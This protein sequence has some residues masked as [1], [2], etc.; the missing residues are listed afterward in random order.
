MSATTWKQDAQRTM[1]V[2]NATSTD[3]YYKQASNRFNRSNS[4]DRA[5][6]GHGDTITFTDASGKV[7]EGKALRCFPGTIVCLVKQSD[8]LVYPR[9]SYA[10]VPDNAFYAVPYMSVTNVVRAIPVSQNDTIPA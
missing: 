1:V 10:K 7:R 5:W 6:I 3:T 2:G 4:P 9:P 8:Q